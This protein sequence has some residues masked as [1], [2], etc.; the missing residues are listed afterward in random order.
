[1]MKCA[2]IRAPQAGVFIAWGVE[3]DTAAAAVRVAAARRLWKWAAAKDCIDLAMRGCPAEGSNIGCRS[4]EMIILGVAEVIAAT[5]E[6]ENR[7]NAA[8]EWMQP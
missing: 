5:A 8:P 1:M 3:I 4:G 7:I 6:A 2:I